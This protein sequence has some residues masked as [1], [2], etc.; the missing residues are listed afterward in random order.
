VQITPFAK[1]IGH[2]RLREIP[3]VITS[4]NIEID[5]SGAEHKYVLVIENQHDHGKYMTITL[6]AEDIR[7]MLRSLLMFDHL[8]ETR[9]PVEDEWPAFVEQPE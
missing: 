5:A 8:L 9:E 6:D 1:N 7:T 4:S 2:G 3:A